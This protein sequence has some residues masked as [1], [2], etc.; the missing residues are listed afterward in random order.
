MQENL[1]SPTYLTH[2]HQLSA[3]WGVL[4]ALLF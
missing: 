3:I 4:G 2:E 1:P